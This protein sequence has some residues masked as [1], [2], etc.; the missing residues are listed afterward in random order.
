MNKEPRGFA[1]RRKPTRA[2][3][4]L[5]AAEAARKAAENR[6]A[7][8]KTDTPRLRKFFTWAMTTGPFDG[9]DLDGSDIQD[10]AVEL[11]LARTEPYD[12]AKHGE[13]HLD[14]MKPGEL[15]CLI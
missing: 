11:G 7:E 13:K 5:H 14:M 6:M 4:V 15:I 10:K 2:C 1:Q 12:P 8:L 3:E 9:C